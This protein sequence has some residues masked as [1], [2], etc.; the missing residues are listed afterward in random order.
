MF[1]L[2]HKERQFKGSGV[3]IFMKVNAS[4]AVHQLK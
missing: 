2:I 3:F 4:K 1:H